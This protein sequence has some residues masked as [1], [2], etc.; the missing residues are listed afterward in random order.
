MGVP[1]RVTGNFEKAQQTCETWAQVYPRDDRPHG[2]LAAFILP[3]SA[4]YEKTIAEAQ[5]KLELDPNAAIGYIILA[6]GYNYLDRY[7]ESE[8]TL[9]QGSERGLE[10][11]E[12]I[13]QRYDLA[14][15]QGH[16]TEMERQVALSQRNADTENWLLDHQAFA[17]AYTGH[18]R[19]ARTMSRRA[20]DQAEQAAHLERAALSETGRAVWEAFSGNTLAAKKSATS[21]LV[22]S[23]Q[24]EVQYGAAFALALAGDYAES[25]T[26]ADDLE[27]RFP[28]DT[29]VRFSY[30]PVLRATVALKHGEPLKSI[31][32]LQISMPYDLG[33]QHSTIHGLFGALY[34]VYVRGEAY[35]AAHRGAEAAVEF[36][37]ILD[38]RGVVVSDPV[39]ALAHLE[40]G[41]A[42]A[43]SEDK[44]RARR[45]YQDFLAL[46]KDADPDVPILKQA[47]AEYSKLE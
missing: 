36:Q 23:N 41:R 44:I 20:A 47:Q 27:N 30:L 39:G 33:T 28:E 5:K 14:F 26:L 13:G 9:R 7:G 35:L 29:S 31:E 22:L 2:Y 42:Y 10:T 25:K 11:P 34:P 40:L 19:E 3:A 45:A 8:S 24:R 37:K 43:L 12:T 1:S 32:L 17:L 21:A 38:H 18:L 6:A 15:L 4:R 46:W 16:A